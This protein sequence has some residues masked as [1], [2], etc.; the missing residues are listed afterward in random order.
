MKTLIRVFLLTAFGDLGMKTEVKRK[1]PRRFMFEAPNFEQVPQRPA[2]MNSANHHVR[3]VV[4]KHQR[5]V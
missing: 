2:K 3:R 1:R 4:Q 5:H